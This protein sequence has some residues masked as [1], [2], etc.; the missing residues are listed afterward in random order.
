MTEIDPTARIAAGAVWGGTPAKPV[1]QWFREMKL[2]ERLAS[3]PDK[4]DKGSTGD[5]R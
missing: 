5:D 1:K 2:L 4:R 3:R